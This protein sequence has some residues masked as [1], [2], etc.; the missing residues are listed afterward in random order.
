VLEFPQVFDL[1]LFD[2]PHF[3]HG[4]V[5]PAVLAEEDG[6]LRPAAH[7]LEVRDLLERDLPGL[8]KSRRERP[9]VSQW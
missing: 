5:A 2:V 8:W 1:R 9:S 3:L 6:S 7:P 4:D